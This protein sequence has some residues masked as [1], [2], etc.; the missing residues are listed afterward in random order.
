MT[1]DVQTKLDEIWA[2]LEDPDTFDNHGSI[3]EEA[4]EHYSQ[5]LQAQCPEGWVC[6]PREPTDEMCRAG[7]SA[8]MFGIEDI[9]GFL[10]ASRCYTTMI[11]AAPKRG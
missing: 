1:D 11:S 7:G 6:V 8:K 10:T 3:V 9:V 5:A 4:L 2:A